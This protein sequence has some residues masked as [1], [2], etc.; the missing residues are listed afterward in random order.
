MA[1]IQQAAQQNQHN[2]QIIIRQ[3]QQLAT[4]IQ[5]N[6]QDIVGALLNVRVKNNDLKQKLDKLKVKE[7]ASGKKDK[8]KKSTQV[9]RRE[10]TNNLPQRLE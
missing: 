8:V 10:L 3:N 2:Q 7:I 6:H 1:A 4:Q 9:K 5:I